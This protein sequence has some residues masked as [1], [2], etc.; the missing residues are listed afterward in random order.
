MPWFVNGITLLVLACP[1]AFV[2]STPVT[3]VS[4][5]HQR[6][7]ERRPHQGR[8]VPRI[9]GSG[10]RRRDGQDRD[11]HAWRT[12]RHRRHSRG[13]AHGRRRPVRT[14][15]RTALR[16]PHRG[17]PSSPTRAT[18]ASRPRRSASS[19]ASPARASRRPSPGRLTTPGSPASSTRSGSTSKRSRRRESDDGVADE[20]RDL[21]D[22][23]GCLNLAEDTIPRL[24]SEGKTVV[25]VGTEDELEGSSPSP[26]T[27]GQRPHGPSSAFRTWA[28]KW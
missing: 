3:V 12:D 1:C 5:H 11:A 8:P 15:T 22:R 4:G 23:Q 16:A 27:F 6:G 19:R 10:R 17:R 14:R 2:I 9:D 28:S 7:E 26:T 25:L 24:Q 21:C 20:V 18:R 13:R